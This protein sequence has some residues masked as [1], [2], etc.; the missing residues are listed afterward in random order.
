MIQIDEVIRFFDKCAPDWDADMV[1]SDEKINRILDNAGVKEGTKVLDVACGTGVLIP[2]YLERNV[3][4]VLGVDISPKMIEIARDKFEGGKVSFLTGDV[5]KE[6]LDR[7]FDAIVVYNAF[8]HFQDG[9]RLIRFLSEHLKEWGRLTIAHGM[10]RERIDAHHKGCACK[11]SNGLE[12]AEELAKIF[13]KYL[14]VTAC[15]STEEMY[16]VAGMKQ[17]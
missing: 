9:E 16:Q 13:E 10:S 8:P 7:D 4:S 14:K 1:K 11:V 6:N 3:G 2:Y 12:P 17:N 15:I 5:E